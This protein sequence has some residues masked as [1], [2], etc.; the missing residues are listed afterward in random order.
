VAGHIWPAGHEFDTCA[1][2]GLNH[3]IRLS[4][5]TEAPLGHMGSGQRSWLLLNAAE[6]L[7]ALPDLHE[8]THNADAP[9]GQQHTLTSSWTCVESADPAGGAVLLRPGPV[10]PCAEEEEGDGD[11]YADGQRSAARALPGQGR[12]PRGQVLEQADAIKYYTLN[13]S[14]ISKLSTC[15]ISLIS[16]AQQIK[17]IHTEPGHVPLIYIFKYIYV[18]LL[19][20]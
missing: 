13:N 2:E 20:K 6:H 18:I 5:P 8:V 9:I 19:Y 12:P 11:R 4:A 15:D 3:I 10:G 1:L 14:T 16:S 17:R 7:S